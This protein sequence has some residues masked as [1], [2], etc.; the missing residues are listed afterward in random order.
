MSEHL[1]LESAMNLS[2]N[3]YN[4]QYE[5][6]RILSSERKHVDRLTVGR[7]LCQLSNC[8]LTSLSTDELSTCSR[9]AYNMYLSVDSS[10]FSLRL[11]YLMPL[12]HYWRAR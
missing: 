10:I 1:F 9:L 5:C 6:Q 3:E 8:W 7:H 4:W 2:K 11:F 12:R